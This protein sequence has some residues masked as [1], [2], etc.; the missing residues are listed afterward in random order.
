M[1]AATITPWDGMPPGDARPGC[2]WFHASIP[3][4][5]L[6]PTGVVFDA[7]PDATEDELRVAA[8]A[9]LAESHTKK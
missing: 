6:G 4:P 8:A 7:K 9:K 3:R 5:G 1:D 2:V